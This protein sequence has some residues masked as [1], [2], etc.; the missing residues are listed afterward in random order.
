[1]LGKNHLNAISKINIVMKIKVYFKGICLNNLAILLPV[2]M[3]VDIE[4]VSF[5]DVLLIAKGDPRFYLFLI[6]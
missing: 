5:Q 1:M 6:F 3:K 4:L 2:T